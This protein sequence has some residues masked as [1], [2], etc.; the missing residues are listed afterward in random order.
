[1]RAG[2]GQRNGLRRASAARAR[3]AVLPCCH[4]LDVCDTGGLSG[5]MDG[6]LAVDAV[7]AQRLKQA[8]YRIWTQR[9]PSAI[10]PKNR[11]LLGMASEWEA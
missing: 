9:I 3:V 4:D 2:Q 1:M 5:W 6:P 10:T 7:R 11:L 8:D